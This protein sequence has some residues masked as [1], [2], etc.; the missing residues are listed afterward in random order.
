LAVYKNVTGMRHGIAQSV[1]SINTIKGS[2]S[3]THHPDRVLYPTL[4][5]VY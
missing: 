5:V 2:F 4:T 1:R 3:C